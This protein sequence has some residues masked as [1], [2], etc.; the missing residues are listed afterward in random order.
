M[1]KMTVRRKHNIIKVFSKTRTLHSDAYWGDHTSQNALLLLEDHAHLTIGSETRERLLLLST[2]SLI[3][4]KSNSSETKD[5]WLCA[6]QWHSERARKCLI[7]NCIILKV[8][9][10]DSVTTA[11][12]VDVSS[13]AESVV[14]KVIQQNA[15]TGKVSEYQLCV[16][17]DGEEEVYP[18]IG[19]ELPF[20]ILLNSLRGQRSRQMLGRHRWHSADEL[21]LTEDTNQFTTSRFILKS[22]AAT[23]TY[24]HAGSLKHKGKQSL[25]GRALRKGHGQSES[26][27]DL[28]P[29]SNKLF[30][31]SLA[32]VCSD[33]N[34]PKVI[35]D[36][37]CMLYHQGPETHG[38]FRRSANAKSCRILKE[39]LNF[40]HG[41]SLCGESVFVAASL[42]TEFLRKLPG[43]VLGC[44]LYEDW[45]NVMKT[46]DEQDRCSSVMSVLAKLPQVNRTLLC[47][48][49]GVLHHIHTHSDMNQM[50]ASN[51]ALCIA[52]NMLWRR[53]TLHPEQD[54]QSTLEVAAL[55]CFLIENTPSIFGD[56]AEKVFTAL[57]DTAQENEDLTVDTPLPLHSSS[58]ETDLDSLPS[59]VFS[60]D[61]EQFL[62]L[63]TLSLSGN[64]NL[65]PFTLATNTRDGGYTC[66]ALDFTSTHPSS[67]GQ[68]WDRCLSEPSMSFDTTTHPQAPPHPPIIRQSSCDGVM[69]NKM[70]RSKSPVLQS[71]SKGA[72]KGRYAFWKSPQFPARFRHPAQRLASMSS[73]SSAATSSLS[74]LESFE[75]APSPN[76]D[77]TRPFLF[78]TSARLRPLT[79]E[80]PKKLWTMA[81]TQDE[82]KDGD[83]IGQREEEKDGGAKH[84]DENEDKGKAKDGQMTEVDGVIKEDRS[85]VIEEGDRGM[86]AE[87]H[88]EGIS[89]HMLHDNEDMELRN[90]Q[91]PSHTHT[92]PLHTTHTSTLHTDLQTIPSKWVKTSR[93]KISLFPSMGWKM[94]K[95]SMRVSV[96]TGGEAV[97]VAQVNT[98]Q[99]LSYD[100]NVNLVLQSEGGRCKISDGEGACTCNEVFI[101]K[102][103]ESDELR[104]NTET[105]NGVSLSDSDVS[106]TASNIST[107]D[108]FNQR[109]AD[110]SQ[111]VHSASI[112]AS[113][114][115]DNKI[116]INVNDSIQT[117]AGNGARRPAT[118]DCVVSISNI[119]Y[120]SDSTHVMQSASTSMSRTVRNSVL[121]CIN[122]IN[123][124]SHSSSPSHGVSIN[125]VSHSVSITQSNANQDAE[126]STKTSLRQTIRI[127]LP[128]TVRSS[129]RAYF[130]PAHTITHTDTQ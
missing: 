110:F 57:L 75:C 50:T 83:T 8:Q 122:D 24:I 47:Y 105:E 76:D 77:K 25:I 111:N 96:E 56:E 40:G 2:D 9:L 118:T 11:V 14:Q 27:P 30:G 62:P 106:Q 16:L 4:A 129:V 116:S 71:R 100:Q 48:V 65:C 93:M 32:S 88:D 112:N 67:L 128:S 78:G 73:L 90:I 41:V 92:C 108:S 28:Q 21:R 99:T 63:N 85:G 59:P 84:L 5:K 80:M 130:S 20:C 43:S 52:P 10:F 3:V 19:H 31:Q 123:S 53:T 58:E 61:L 127:R 115:T 64:R 68:S 125:T 22:T 79:P 69:H 102:E 101:S 124:V 121:D 82:L 109:A 18:L 13:T 89:R 39:K 15:L 7:P 17:N 26:Q 36:L 126:S 74:S 54:N 23:H 81:F 72:G 113:A 120:D 34:L 103:A 95:Q 55:V 86:Q 97:T 91:T 37:L 117:N 49:F 114:S 38:I 98:P 45:I 1:M 104:I 29:A 6:L 87:E 44:D 119:G 51:L 33:G 35:M 70:T 66:S 60:P 12:S 42:L 107:S 46:V 94:F